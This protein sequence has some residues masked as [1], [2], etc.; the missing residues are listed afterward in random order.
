[1]LKLGNKWTYV[2]AMAVLISCSS[3]GQQ[4]VESGQG[5]EISGTVGF[6]QSGVVVLEE[7][8]AVGQLGERDTIEVSENYTYSLRKVVTT[9]GI[10]RLNFY[11]LQF[12][13]I[14]LDDEDVVVNV[15]G[16]A[17]N[18]FVQITGST[19][20]QLL[21]EYQ[22]F[23]GEFQ[24]S[25]QMQKLNTDFQQAQQQGDAKLMNDLRAN[26]MEMQAAHNVRSAEMILN[27]GTSL[28]ALQVVTSLDKDQHFD[29]Y[30]AVA[31]KFN[32]LIPENQFVKQFSE[33]V[34]NMKLLAIGE[35]A[36]EIALPN[37]EGEVVKLSSLRGKYVL[38]DFWA[39]WCG[40]C[41]KENPNVV[42]AYNK[43][44]KK[45]FEVFGVSL[46][47]RREDWVKAIAEDGLHWTQVSDLKF[48]QS[49]AAKTYN[50]TAIPF[51]LLLDK[52]GKIIAK[53]LRGQALDDKLAELMGE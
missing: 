41:R 13:N 2:L 44:N 20:H 12:V 49:E 32:A 14:I 42:R 8:L 15:D 38:V 30:M 5:I 36:P 39:K 33:Q 50:I 43:Y 18:G 28:T 1:M 34:E 45:G 23:Q 3:T 25:E 37:P 9:P 10:Y 26:Y 29:T 6:P 53:N 7:I 22:A 27:M 46:D 40:P 24:R 52:E 21:D 4:S 11:G 17:K 47:R 48:W 19:D 16:N 35:L 31:T 51:A